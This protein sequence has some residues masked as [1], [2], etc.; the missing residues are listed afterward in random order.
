M[1]G[2]A[3]AA[4]RRRRP[5]TAPREPILPRRL[6]VALCGA[7]GL[8]PR[9]SCPRNFRRVPTA[10]GRPTKG[11]GPDPDPHRSTTK[12]VVVVALLAACA[13]F[14]AGAVVHSPTL[15]NK[16]ASFPK[17]IPEKDQSSKELE[18]DP[19]WEELGVTQMW[20]NKCLFTKADMEKCK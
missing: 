7:R 6:R 10:A 5:P 16:S 15:V 20:K 8:S 14:A 3:R 18:E 17:A 11:K 2:G 19:C 9:G 4:P 13:G 1:R 12:F